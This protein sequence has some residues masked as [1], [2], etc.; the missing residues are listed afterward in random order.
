MQRTAAYLKSVRSAHVRWLP[1]GLIA[2]V[3]VSA[4]V[5]SGVAAA[6]RGVDRD[7]SVS[8][9]QVVPSSDAKLAQPVFATTRGG[10]ARHLDAPQPVQLD[11]ATS[12]GSQDSDAVPASSSVRRRRRT[13]STSALPPPTPSPVLTAPRA[14]ST[15]TPTVRATASPT[16]QPSATATPAVGILGVTPTVTVTLPGNEPLAALGWTGA[17]YNNI[18]LSGGV[19]ATR[20][21]GPVLAFAW[22]GSP[23]AGVNADYFSVR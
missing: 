7:N 13:S 23:A 9:M 21:D 6:G 12:S 4:L 1:L 15:S 2:G 14:T 22:P 16:P 20:Q 10:Q 18:S 3:A 8:S 17:Y 19:A 11:G 5:V